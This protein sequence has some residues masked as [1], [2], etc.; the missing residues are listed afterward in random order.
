V[1][2]NISTICTYFHNICDGG[3]QRVMALQAKLWIDMGYRVVVLT[4]QAPTENDYLLPKNVI[5]KTFPP[6]F[7]QTRENFWD[8]FIKSE[9]IDVVINNDWGSVIY[10]KD[11]LC[12]KK[13]GAFFVTI[14]HHNFSGW[15]YF[16]QNTYD[17]HNQKLF[18]LLDA[19]VTLAPT[20]QLWWSCLGAKAY[21]IPNPL[22]FSPETT[23]KSSP[24]GRNIIWM[25]RTNDSGKKLTDAIL[26][27]SKIVDRFSDARLIVIGP[28]PPKLFEKTVRRLIRQL[29]LGTKVTLLG[30][31]NDISEYLKNAWVH[32]STSIVESFSMVIAEACAYSIPT[33][34]YELPYLAITQANKGFLAVPQGDIVGLADALTKVLADRTLRD[35]LGDEAKTNLAQFKDRIIT[36]G[37]KNLFT[38][39]EIGQISTIDINIPYDRLQDFQAIVQE[40]NRSQNYLFNEHRWKIKIVNYMERFFPTDKYG[41]SKLKPFLQWVYVTLYRRSVRLAKFI[42]ILPPAI[43]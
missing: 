40:V 24:Y 29:N 1:T 2:S 18:P 7:M 19:L 13:A 12:V 15:A 17:F 21:Y 28:L 42:R 4:E 32:L 20:Q 14:I 25:G 26:V 27:F 16:F 34:M 41:N 36:Q 33:V 5:R 38:R 3:L 30:F 23:P 6:V 8:I 9:K 31:T 11:L 22:T 39:L 35:R 43:F 37:W 10:E